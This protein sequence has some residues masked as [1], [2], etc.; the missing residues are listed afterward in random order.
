MTPV[1]TFDLRV[2]YVLGSMFVAAGFE[3]GWLWPL[4][5]SRVLVYGGVGG[6]WHV[7]SCDR[8]T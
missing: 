4:A 3:V 2:P 8:C 5:A 7:V 6:Y 1:V